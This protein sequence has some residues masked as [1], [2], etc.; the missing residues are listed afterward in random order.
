MKIFRVYICFLF[1]FTGY[2]LS[3]SQ[4]LDIGIA[5]TRYVYAGTTFKNH[6][7]VF[8]SESLFSENFKNQQIE[9]TGF[10]RNTLYK[11][12]YIGGFKTGSSW[13]GS[14]QRY[15]IFAG[16]AYRPFERWSL[17]TKLRPNYDTGYGY[18]TDWAVGLKFNAFQPLWLNLDFTTIPDYRKSEKR[19]HFGA[20]FNVGALSASAIIS[21][22]V[23]GDQKF[24]TWRILMGLNYCFNLSKSSGNSSFQ[25]F[26]PTY[27]L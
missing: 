10:Y 1:L 19:L 17:E 14:Y 11:F 22:P 12:S 13:C 6:F 25:P 5:K 9:L 8:L 4:T 18:S 27:N 16:I 15:A 2:F 20:L 26:S 7:G 3:F 21:I 24:K 23:E